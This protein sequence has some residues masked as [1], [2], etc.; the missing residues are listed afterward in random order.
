MQTKTVAYEYK[1]DIRNESGFV[2]GMQRVCRIV[3]S[4]NPFWKY[5]MDKNRSSI[6]Y[7][8]VIEKRMS[9]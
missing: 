7:F 4:L 3:S 8:C 6:G 2:L 1:L 5:L 9:G